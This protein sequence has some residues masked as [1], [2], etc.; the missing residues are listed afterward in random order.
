M[1]NERKSERYYCKNEAGHDLFFVELIIDEELDFVYM[2]TS[3]NYD[4]GNN[5]EILELRKHITESYKLESIRDSFIEKLFSLIKTLPGIELCYFGPEYLN[6]NGKHVPEYSAVL[7]SLLKNK[8]FP[9]YTVFSRNINSFYFEY[10]LSFLYDKLA[11]G[12]VKT[13]EK[14]YFEK[15]IENDISLSN[16]Y[17]EW[18]TENTEY[19]HVIL[20]DQKTE[21]DCFIMKQQGDIKLFFVRLVILLHL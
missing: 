6:K 9:D 13:I 1:Y 18:L 21:Y 12:I 7:D 19:F 2:D 4:F 5:Q 8:D 3:L 15:L 14:K 11:E 17:V 20:Y 16:E 10:S